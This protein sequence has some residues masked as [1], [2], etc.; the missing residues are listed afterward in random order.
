MF[1]C[2]FVDLGSWLYIDDCE[3]DMNGVL[4]VLIKP[5]GLIKCD[6]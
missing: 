2:M 1:D 6:I 3:V 4:R 5:F